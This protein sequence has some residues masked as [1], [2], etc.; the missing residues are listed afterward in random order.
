[1]TRQSLR[2]TKAQRLLQ[3]TD[4]DAVFNQPKRSS[5]AYFTILA[6]PNSQP[7]ARLGLAI[8]KKQLRYAHERNWVKRL[9]RESFRQHQNQLVGIDCVVLCKSAAKI[10][11]S[12]TLS[13]ALKA[14]WKRV[15]KL[16]H[17]S[18]ENVL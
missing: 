6:K 10:Q 9:I 17:S 11:P 18:S 16:C 12:V 5:D 14:H 4:F 13:N 7:K 3:K 15:I 8:A 1:M 2:F